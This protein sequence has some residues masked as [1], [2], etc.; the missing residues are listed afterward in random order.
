M[1]HISD[2]ANVPDLVPEMLQVAID[3]VEGQKGSNVAQVYVAVYS[4]AA[5]IHPHEWRVDGREFFFCSGQA[6]AD[7]QG[8]HGSLFR[9]EARK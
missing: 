1:A 4:G 7:V 6:V 2:V 8:I 9:F 5:H 3:D